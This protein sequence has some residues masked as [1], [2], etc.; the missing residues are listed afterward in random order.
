MYHSGEVNDI[1]IINAALPS[2]VPS[3][4]D[5]PPVIYCSEGEASTWRRSLSSGGRTAPHTYS[6]DMRRLLRNTTCMLVVWFVVVSL[7]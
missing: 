5:C 1:D 4:N 7:Y 3:K 2:I 6:G